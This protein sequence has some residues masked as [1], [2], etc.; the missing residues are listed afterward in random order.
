MI[1]RSKTRLQNHSNMVMPLGKAC[2]G[3]LEEGTAMVHIIE[4]GQGKVVPATG[5]AGE[6]F[7]GFA[8]MRPSS[9]D[10]LTEAYTAVIDAN[11]AILRLEHVSF[12]GG[13][14][15]VVLEADGSERRVAVQASGVA[16]TDTATLIDGGLRVQFATSDKGKKVSVLA[17]Y[18]P[19]I[20]EAAA[21]YG[22]SPCGVSQSEV[23][24]ATMVR[25]YGQIYYTNVFDA[26]A[27][28]TLKDGAAPKL[29]LT[30]GGKLT[31]TVTQSPLPEAVLI[32]SPRGAVTSGVAYV[33]VALR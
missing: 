28:W 33:G 19:T 24:A 21:I 12:V 14:G 7:A 15:L 32:S 8:T 3:L 20:Q 27:D 11:S 29:Y 18:V 31:T 26:S 16:T 25:G 2:V 13:L 23:K 22:Q 10:R 9:V 1:D 30:A 6:V 5:V 4:D 17:E